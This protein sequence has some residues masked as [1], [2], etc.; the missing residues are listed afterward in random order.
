ME[1]SGWGR[2]RRPSR[3]PQGSPGCQPAAAGACLSPLVPVGGGSAPVP[4]LGSEKLPDGSPCCRPLL[5]LVVS[6]PHG[7]HQEP[8]DPE[9]VSPSAASPADLQPCRPGLSSVRV[10]Q[11]S[12]AVPG[13]GP[14]FPES[15]GA[16]PGTKRVLA[17]QP[18]A[19]L[20]RMKC[21]QAPRLRAAHLYLCA[22]LMLRHRLGLCRV[23]IFKKM[24]TCT[25]L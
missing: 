15:P 17:Q 3:S 6:V 2:A 5:V 12:A 10:S 25:F 13:G 24:G 1:T 19:R 8:W 23:C 4:V 22:V 11:E 7:V 16:A 14:L 21:E 9:A 18:W 20:Q